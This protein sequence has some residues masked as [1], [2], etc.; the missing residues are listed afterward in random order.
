M[1]NSDS[2]KHDPSNLL[3]IGRTI[4]ANDR[5]MLAFF[6]TSLAF[7]AAGIG[8]I[9]Y[10]DHLA[11]DVIGWIFIGLACAFLIWGTHRYR[12]VKRILKAV[13]PED[14]KAAEKEMGL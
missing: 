5:T 1:E 11:Y 8:L 3:T 2:S 14:Q 10:L 7:C 12:H 4:M 6:R 13:T 9:K